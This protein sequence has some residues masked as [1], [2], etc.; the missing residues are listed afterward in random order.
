MYL[1]FTPAP[2]CN[3]SS[4]MSFNTADDLSALDLSLVEA[5]DKIREALRRLDFL[6]N[7]Y[8]LDLDLRHALAQS[9]MA[10]TNVPDLLTAVLSRHAGLFSAAEAVGEVGLQVVSPDDSD[11]IP[12]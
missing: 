11:D 6:S 7:A 5:N 12:F 4:P 10:L 2:T 1:H 3:C 8:D 9:C